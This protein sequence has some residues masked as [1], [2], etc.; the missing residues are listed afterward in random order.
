VFELEHF[1][2]SGRCYD[3]TKFQPPAGLQLD[4]SRNGRIR[5]DTTVMQNMGYF[6]LQANPSVW[7]IVLHG[8]EA[9][10]IYEIEKDSQNKDVVVDTTKESNRKIAVASF[11]ASE[12]RLNVVRKPGMK[13]AEL[14]GDAKKSEGIWDSLFGKR[15]EKSSSDETL[16]VFSLASG[17]LYERFLKIMMLSVIKNTQSP[18]KFWF[19]K[20]FASPQFKNFAPKMAKH[21]GYELEFVTYKW[22]QWL[23]RQTEK[24]RIIWGYKI[25]F[26]DVLFPLNISRIIY[27]DA[28][29]IVRG[30]IKE[31][32]DMDLK[33]AVYG[34]TP[35]C[36]SN[37][38]TEG[39]R[40]WKTGYWKDHLRGSPYHIS[41]LYVVD[42]DLF[43]QKRAGDTL[44]MVYDNLSQDP[45]SLSNL[46][47]DLPNYVQH[48]VK[49]FS[50]PQEWLWCQ[51]WCSMETLVTA[52]TIDLCNNPLTK[53][54]KLEVAKSILPEWEVYDNEAKNLEAELSK[55][56]DQ[57]PVSF[58]PK[59][60][61]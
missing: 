18:V 32:W 43:R 28:D 61:L 24:Q 8:V 39:F 56:T 40:F 46:D 50:L 3:M 42:L 33:G 45:N 36:D 37:K 26:L 31:L 4:L 30:D 27:I 11:D 47:Q 29:Q 13:N 34:Y 12:I 38:E 17:H 5:T 19:I 59:Q 51:T 25:L 44:R 1:L 10:S 60:E 22:P 54:P 20:N 21:Y 57:R 6:Q 55:K 35:F 14:G 48:Q 16:H 58:K 15:R 49:I 41:A 53:T 52:K 23:R 2:V 9:N 7:K